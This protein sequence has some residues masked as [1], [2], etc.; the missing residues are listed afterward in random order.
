MSSRLVFSRS[1]KAGEDQTTPDLSIQEGTEPAYHPVILWCIDPSASHVLA[2]R[3]VP[4]EEMSTQVPLVLYDALVAS[5]LPRTRVATGL[6]WHLPKQITT[7]LSLGHPCLAAC[8]RAGLRVEEKRVEEPSVLHTVRET[9][10]PGVAGQTLPTRSW[11]TLLDSYL[12]RV[13][14]HGPLRE[15][16]QRIRAYISLIG[17]NQDPAWQF[18]LLRSLLPQHPG[19]ITPEGTVLYDGL[20]YTHELLSYWLGSP[21]ALRQ[22]I[23]AE[24]TAWIYLDEEILCQAQAQELRRQDGTYRPFR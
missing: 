14:G 1:T 2:F 20:H 5:R 17:Y 16:K 11:V 8:Q 22:S 7:A 23:Y 12:H 3:I 19:T 15:L 10:E 9:W 6:L 4:P 21:I 13:H 24:A 18:P